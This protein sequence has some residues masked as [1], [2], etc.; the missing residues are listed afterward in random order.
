MV[1]YSPEAMSNQTCSVNNFLL[2]ESQAYSVM[3][4]SVSSCSE[5]RR[6]DPDCEKSHTTVW[7][8]MVKYLL[9]LV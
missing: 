8:F 6:S 7:P 3:F 4:I 1:D 2:E 5:L 9:T